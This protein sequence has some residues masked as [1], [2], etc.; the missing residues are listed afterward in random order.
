MNKD[1]LLTCYANTIAEQ[2]KE[3][4]RLGDELWLAD[5]AVVRAGRMADRYAEDYRKTLKW[6]PDQ[7]LA[8]YNVAP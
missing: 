8:Q 7:I 2:A 4:L 3:I 5:Q 1:K 6:D